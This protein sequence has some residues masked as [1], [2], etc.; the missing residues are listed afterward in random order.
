MGN[1][2]E[3]AFQIGVHH[4]PIAFLEQSID[5]PEGVFASPVWPKAVAV[6][7][8][9]TLKDRLQH[10]AQGRLNDPVTNR[11]DSQGPPLAAARLG[12][13]HP[14]DFLGTVGAPTQLLRQ[15]PQIRSQTLRIP[16]DRLMVT[17]RRP[18]VGLHLR[19]G[20]PQV[21]HAVDLVN[22]AEPYA[23]FHS[24]FKGRQH[25]FGPDHAFRPRPPGPDFSDGLSHG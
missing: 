22:Q 4:V 1:R 13:M 6:L 21:G 3:V 5:P 8:K 20:G 23:S 12:N 19:E 18:T 15:V 24:S 2:V 10:V 11:R 16:R 17:S 7:G 9:I 14:P 25:A